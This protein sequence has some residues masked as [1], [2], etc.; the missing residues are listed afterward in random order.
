MIHLTHP[1]LLAFVWWHLLIIQE[2][3]G[4]DFQKVIDDNLS[5][6]LARW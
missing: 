6:L 1:Y 3:L 4:T 2:P 5:E